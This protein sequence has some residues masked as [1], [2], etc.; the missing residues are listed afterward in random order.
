MLVLDAFGELTEL[1][2]FLLL[3]ETRKR[4]LFLTFDLH[5]D[6]AGGQGLKHLNEDFTLDSVAGLVEGKLSLNL[7]ATLREIASGVREVEHSV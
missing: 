4:R 5:L 1:F 6:K 7:D 2:T 3:P